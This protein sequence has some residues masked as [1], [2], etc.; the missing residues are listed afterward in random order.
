MTGPASQ[1][2][3]RRSL[4]VRVPL[5]L[6]THGGRKLIVTPVGAAPAPARPRIDHTMVKALARAHRW[7]RLLESG[8]FASVE[9]PPPLSDTY[10]KVIASSKPLHQR[11]IHQ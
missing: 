3:K 2:Q 8:R 11:K 9:E 4:T 6:R 10:N 7:K 5:K 1:N